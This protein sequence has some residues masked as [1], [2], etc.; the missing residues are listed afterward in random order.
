MT[1]S[2][3]RRGV[4]FDLDGV[5]VMSEHLWEEAWQFYALQ[6]GYE[7]TADDTR[8]CQG[9]SVSEW[10]SYVA[11]RTSGNP[12]AAA[13]DVVDRVNQSYVAGRVSLASG[14][15]E[16][17]AAVAARVPIGLASSAPRQI[18]DTVMETMGIGP[19][20]SATVSS[21]EV[22]RGKPSPDVY[23]EAVQRLG[24]DPSGSLAVEDSSNG[25]RAAAAAGLAVIAVAH[26]PYPLAPDAAALVA[27]VQH[28]LAGV[29][30]E[31]LRMLDRPM[32]GDQRP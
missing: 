18:I 27:S 12:A 21:A 22:R 31:I 11:V 4:V 30:I 14:A 8:Q 13:R 15:E 23:R 24:I 32:P 2:L 26:E 1:P 10:A 20:F 25:V 17:V 7:W 6:R 3:R 5:L 29:K 19:Y 16:L 9:M 28:S